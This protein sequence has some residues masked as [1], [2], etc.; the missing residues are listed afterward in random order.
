MMF[1]KDKDLVFTA[2]QV[3]I[4]SLKNLNDSQELLIVGIVSSFY[5]DYLFGKKGHQIPLLKLA[6]K[7]RRIW[8]FVDYVIGRILI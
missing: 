8:M 7:L 2:F 6:D 3:V 1:S 5:R 4:S